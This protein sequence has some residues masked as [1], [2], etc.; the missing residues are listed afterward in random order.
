MV[1]KM[2]QL[3]IGVF[4]LSISAG[5]FI[6]AV[7][8]L[9]LLLK[10]VPKNIICV[11]WLLVGIRLLIPFSIESVFGVVPSSQIMDENIMYDSQP[12]I[13]SGVT[14]IDRN[15]NQYLQS[16]SLLPQEA[17][18]MNPMQLVVMIFTGIWVVGMFLMFGYFIIS[19]WN[20]ARRV[21]NAVLIE[22]KYGRVYESEEIGEPFLL[23]I[24]HPG[25]YLPTEL[26]EEEKSFVLEH[27]RAHIIRR[28]YLIK[29]ISFLILTVY[30][31]HPLVWAA[32]L[33][34]CRDIE[35]ACDERVIRKLGMECKKEYSQALL[36]CSVNRRTI[37]ACP[38]AFGEVGVK[39]RVKNILDYKKPRFWVILAAVIICIIT[40]LC[41]LTQR[42]SNGENEQSA[43]QVAEEQGTTLDA[44]NEA[45]NDNTQ[46]AS[47]YYF[48]IPKEYA[49]LITYH[50]ENSFET[51]FTDSTGD[52]ILGSIKMIAAGE[53]MKL[54]TDSYELVG[55]YGANAML[56]QM[57][58]GNQTIHNYSDDTT[59]IYESNE[60]PAQDGVQPIPN[61]TG[62]YELLELEEQEYLPTEQIDV[63]AISNYCYLFLYP[64]ESQ[65]PNEQ[66]EQFKECQQILV[67]MLDKIQIDEV[68]N[69]TSISAYDAVTTYA[70]A[71]AN[72]DGETIA[73]LLSEKVK[74]DMEKRDLLLV[75][76]DYT[77]FGWS[78]PWPMWSDP[79]YEIVSV[80]ENKGQAEIRYFADV[81]DPH[82]TVWYETITYT[83]ENGKYL[84]IDESLEYM[85]GIA[86]A[87]EFYRA[88]PNGKITDTPMDYENSGSGEALNKNAKENKTL[89]WY[90]KLFA[91]DTA[92]IYLL[93]LIDNENKVSVFVD[94]SSEGVA[95]LSILFLEDN[96]RV[97]VTM[98]QPY[99]ADGI[100]I[101]KDNAA[102]LE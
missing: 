62:D 37:A 46:E 43:E 22:D 52:Y 76:E 26:P 14:V 96:S 34:L 44:A 97:G 40:S 61:A 24:L 64:D 92:A 48:E 80:D 98:V 87:E 75:G 41:F 90:S 63:D 66:R 8:V 35:L 47:I 29:P 28:D 82:V 6:I 11:L 10:K 69:S 94:N 53:A 56:R 15:M 45:A 33:L 65:W 54:P 51:V 72:R 1:I 50:N 21:K 39:E 17:G 59:Y 89:E 81:S 68:V 93:N 101:P 86:S 74:N 13:H 49:D 12:A 23:G 67:S 32:Y 58:E 71:F 9:R 31:F 85:D 60:V 57:N 79:G 27:E 100:W 42:K 78:S 99:G 18:S 91:P 70:E 88:Y 95:Q 73:P 77:S 19:W 5:Y 2:E 7:I 84:I 38:V 25:I 102:T 36:N 30:W 55:D 3:F 4:N 20:I 83:T 16:E